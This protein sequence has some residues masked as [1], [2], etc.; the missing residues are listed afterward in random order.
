[1]KKLPIS[2]FLTLIVFSSKAQDKTSESKTY[3]KLNVEFLNNSTYLGRQDSLATPYFTPSFTYFNKSGFYA[4]IYGSLLARKGSFRMDVVTLGGGYDFNIGNFNGD[5]S[6]EKNF[7]SGKSSNVK[8]EV[9]GSLYASG[10][11]DFN[12]FSLY[13]EPGIN[14]SSKSDVFVDAGVQKQFELTEGLEI[15][16]SFQVNATTR[17]FYSSYFGKRKNKKNNTATAPII[18]AEVV[19][20]SKMKIMN[21][22]LSLPFSFTKGKTTLDFSPVYSLASNPAVITKTIKL[23]PTAIPVITNETE[24]LSNLFYFTLG[25]SV[26]F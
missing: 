7:Y 3:N 22:E 1:M 11:Y 12:F 2:V 8:S 17:N 13:L 24:K 23:T 6:V 9:Q 5:I 4:N 16:P 10:S 26:K 15:S 14:F 18:T 19:D 21:M 20:A 25:L